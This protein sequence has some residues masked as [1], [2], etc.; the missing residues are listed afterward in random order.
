MSSDTL[1]ININSAKIR[2]ITDKVIKIYKKCYLTGK[3]KQI[4]LVVLQKYE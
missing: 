1:N 3:K 4:K 2:Q